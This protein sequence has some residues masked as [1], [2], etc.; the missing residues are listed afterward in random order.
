MKNTPIDAQIWA[1]IQ[2]KVFQPTACQLV[3]PGPSRLAQG[4]GRFDVLNGTAFGPLTYTGAQDFSDEMFD[5]KTL[6]IIPSGGLQAI[7]MGGLAL[8][9]VNEEIGYLLPGMTFFPE[10]SGG[11][12]LIGYGEPFADIR[13]EDVTAS[14]APGIAF[15]IGRVWATPCRN[16]RGENLRDSL[17]WMPPDMTTLVNLAPL[18]AYLA[19]LN[20]TARDQA[21]FLTTELARKADEIRAIHENIAYWKAKDETEGC[22]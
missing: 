10:D 19:G 11:I 21:D 5:Y 6:C 2:G 1:L 16:R 20:L 17:E 4:Y 18:A 14:C 9:K 3:P 22:A 13:T 12:L 8:H 15:P 7:Q